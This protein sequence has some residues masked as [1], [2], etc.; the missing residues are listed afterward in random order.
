MS[1][2][3]KKVISS[4]SN[5]EKVKTSVVI[6]LDK[7]LSIGGGERKDSKAKPTVVLKSLTPTTD[8]CDVQLPLDNPSLIGFV[9]LQNDGERSVT[10]KKL[11]ERLALGEIRSQKTKGL[12]Q[13]YTTFLRIGFYGATNSSGVLNAS[14]TLDP[15]GTTDWSYFSSLFDEFRVVKVSVWIHPYSKFDSSKYGQ[16]VAVFDNDSSTAPAT[17]D[18]GLQYGTAKS[19]Q[20]PVGLKAHWSR[21]NLTDSAYWTDVASPSGSTGSVGYSFG[22][23]NAATQNIIGGV[24]TYHIQFRSRR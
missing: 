21:P 18:A 24:A 23:T 19:F 20:V 2:I 1:Q 7:P 10:S 22:L 11:A 3:L 9:P 12:G 16:G 15:S 17:V 6:P 5:E 14:V 4:T 13:F 8:D